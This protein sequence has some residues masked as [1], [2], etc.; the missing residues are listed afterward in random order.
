MSESSCSAAY[1]KMMETIQDNYKI[2]IAMY[3]NRIWVTGYHCVAHIWKRRRR[4]IARHRLTFHPVKKRVY[5]F[6]KRKKLEFF[7]RYKRGR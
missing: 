5:G 4:K 6:N 2:V 7:G 3:T 1:Q